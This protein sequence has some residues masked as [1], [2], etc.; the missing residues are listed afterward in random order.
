MPVRAV[1]P[2]CGATTTIDEAS[3]Q[4]AIECRQCGKQVPVPGAKPGGPPPLP[5]SESA[6][7]DA[8][9]EVLDDEEEVDDRP[10][11]TRSRSR[12][13]D[14]GE[15][16]RPEF[17]RG[18]TMRTTRTTIVPSALVGCENRK[19]T[20]KRM[21]VR[22]RDTDE[23]T[24]MMKTMRRNH[25][26]EGLPLVMTMRKRMMTNHPVEARPLVAMMMKTMKTRTMMIAPDPGGPRRTTTKTRTTRRRTSRSMWMK[27]RTKTTKIR[28]APPGWGRLR[29]LS[30]RR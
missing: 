14:S 18:T 9:F 28:S 12:D 1:C 17:A 10:P 13:D 2:E 27:M 22:D 21:I 6:P 24:M 26:A 5:K 19:T 8:G 4:K 20:T 30:R 15:R 23:M 11:V 29:Q 3:P 25:P 7:A 16:P